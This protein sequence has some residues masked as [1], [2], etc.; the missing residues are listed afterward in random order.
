M[1]M[2]ML[3]LSCMA[4]PSHG[5]QVDASRPSS[6]RS[7]RSN[8]QSKGNVNSPAESQCVHLFSAA[9]A[10]AWA[11]Q[12][13]VALRLSVFHSL[14]ATCMALPRAI[15]KSIPGVLISHSNSNPAWI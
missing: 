7:C 12:A 2:C 14:G 6:S 13:K 4:G 15:L 10:C 5:D 9:A 1:L 11:S 8:S 3:K